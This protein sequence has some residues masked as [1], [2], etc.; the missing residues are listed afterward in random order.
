MAANKALERGVAVTMPVPSA[1]NAGLGPVSGEPLMFGTGT[2]PGYGLAGV[3]QNSYTPP[4]GVPTGTVS[5]DFEGAYNLTVIAKSSLSPSTGK[6][7]NPGDKIY[8]DGGTLDTT[9]GC[10]Y[11]FT[12]DVNS[13][14]G[15]YYG[16][17]LDA[18]TSGSSGVVRVRLKVTG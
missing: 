8:A 12:L 9:T 16:N 4:T 7:I 10:L 1:D 14:S 18:L 5:V 13:S 11:G 6:A 17:S 2:A 15:I 3:A